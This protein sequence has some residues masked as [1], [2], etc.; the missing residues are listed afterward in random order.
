MSGAR[1]AAAR[2]LRALEQGRVTRLAPALRLDRLPARERDLALE[3]AR[4]VERMRLTLDFVLGQFVTRNLP[5]DAGTRTA[6]R[7]GAYQ[8]LFLDRV[9][10]HA[11]VDESVALAGR[12]RAFVNA[13]LRRL[14]A[15][16][17][18]RPPGAER[19]PGLPDAAG[20]PARR[21]ALAHGLPE[22]LVQRW[23]AAHG[24]ERAAQIAE[25]SATAGAVTLRATA[26][27]ATRAELRA[28]LQ[29]DG[30]ETEELAH[31]RLLRWSG[32]RSPFA[33]AAYTEGWFLIQDE[34]AALAVDAVAARPGS[35]VLD[36]CA[37]PGTKTAVLAEQVG[38][39]GRVLAYDA[40]AERRAQIVAN[41]TR[42]RLGG[43]VTVLDAL[44]A[45]LGVDAAL[46][47]VPCSNTGVLGK[48]VEVRRWIRPQTF[49]ELAPEQRE[50]LEQALASVRPQGRVVYSTCS[51]EPEEN[52]AVV[53]A[54]ARTPASLE[55]ERLTFPEAGQRDGG[56]FAVLA[57]LR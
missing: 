16:V 12:D 51:L 15:V 52:H 21:L 47:D 42:L 50:L 20:E 45:G 29:A 4:G 5:E 24:V 25:A 26:L 28:R 53:E 55:L 18:G 54:A 11:A 9:P 7:L 49:G 6:L 56:Y 13:V 34:T 46:A 1:R 37:A 10:A 3:L 19:I 22:F 14:A 27:A 33:S 39:Q 40:R 35:T 44:P 8:L 36:L 57:R 41:V 17:A 38:G 23:V 32:G 30:V 31:A 48:R 43:I 2:A